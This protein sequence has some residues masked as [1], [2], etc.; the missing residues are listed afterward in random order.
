MTAE[1]DATN[2]KQRLEALEA[3]AVAEATAT[4]D[5]AFTPSPSLLN[6]TTPAPLLKQ[7]DGPSLENYEAKESV[8]VGRS[9]PL[10]AGGTL[11]V[12]ISVTT[13]GSVVEYAVENKMYDFGFGITAEREEGVTLVKVCSNK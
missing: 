13:P 8:Y 11:K 10:A 12:P 2:E 7:V 6:A 4:A 5:A 3:K 1:T 9:V